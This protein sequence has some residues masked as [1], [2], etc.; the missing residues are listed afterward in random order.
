MNSGSSHSQ[1]GPIFLV[2]AARSGTTL[3]QYM[4]RSHPHLSAPTGESHFII[5]LCREA[6]KFGD[7]KDAKNVARVLERM[8][9]ISREF[10]D[11]D[12]H[13]IQ[14]DR[15]ALAATMAERSDGTM[16]GLIRTLFELNAEGEGK[17]RWI[18]KTPYYI[19]HLPWLAKTFPDARFVHIIRDGRDCA[20]SMLRRAR[21]LRIFNIYHAAQFWSQY[22]DAG[23]LAAL[24]L[25]KN[26]YHELHYEKL[27]ERPEDVLRELCKFLGEPFDQRLI[28]FQTSGDSGDRTP[29][30]RKPLQ[31]DNQQKWRQ[32]MTPWQI[33]VFESEAGDT[34]RRNGYPLAFPGRSRLPLPARIP[35]RLHIQAA[36]YLLPR[37]RQH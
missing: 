17:S 2:G 11:E 29:L 25:P 3:L 10:M 5:P 15:A 18:D 12:L 20:L 6:E 4:L 37:K 19:L 26:R 35:Y 34:L 8:R 13:G 33:R 32:K 36:K 9:D 21:D 30:L 27:L 31:R 22:V 23:Q 24:D 28:D 1:R 16:P 14:M 7:L